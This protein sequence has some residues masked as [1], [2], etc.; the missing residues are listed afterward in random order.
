MENLKDKTVK[1]VFWSAFNRFS[2]Q[3][4]QFVFGI[5]IA[6]ILLPEEYGVVA[7]LYVFIEI[8]DCFIDSGFANALIR[9]HD[10]TDEDFSTVF[11]YNLVVA[12]ICYALLWCASPYIAAFY[13]IPILENITKV[14]GLGLILGSIQTI[15]GIK[16]TIALD[17]KT[18]AK[19]SI[20]SNIIIGVLGLW[21]AYSG[22]GV[23]TLVIPNLIAGVFRIFMCWFY[24]R[25]LPALTF[26]W[27]SF[28][29]MFSF[30]SKLLASSLIDKVFSNIYTILIGKF[31]NLSALGCYKRAGMFA[32]FFSNNITGILQNVTLP[33]LSSIQNEDE[34]LKSIYSSIIRMS[35]FVIFPLMLGLSAVAD[36]FIRILLTDKWEDSISLLQIICF[37][38]MWYPVHALNLNLLQVKGR[39][40]YFL[41]LEIMKK[42][43]SIL[44]IFVTFP[45]GLKAICYGSVVTSLI[46]VVW[47]THYTKKIIGYGFLSQIHDIMPT[48]LHSLVMGV[49][50]HIV[51]YLMPTLWFKLIMGIIVGALY[52]IGGAYIMKFKELREVF[53]ILKLTNV[54]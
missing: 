4:L 2:T 18:G 36:P 49:L 45:F 35:V 43:T 51:V 13:D 30:G 15:M 47:N 22:Y 3:G 9:K 44:F 24:V 16:L 17:F 48:L 5:L 46:S 34:R 40:D 27:K 23:W 50:V 25:W 52:Y 7:L 20:P 12:L 33:V 53:N 32:S 14:V 21:M 29:E 42:I 41:K 10:R 39:S 31:F 37:A 1:G 11:Y 8:L 19:I 54:F 38:L 6:R 28:K 26:S